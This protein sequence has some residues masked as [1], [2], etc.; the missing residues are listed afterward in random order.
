LPERHDSPD[1][2]SRWTF[3][4]TH[5]LGGGHL[6]FAVQGPLEL[7]AAAGTLEEAASDVVAQVA[8]MI[9]GAAAVQLP[10]PIQLFEVATC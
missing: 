8:R 1:P 6:V 5:A 7:R 10:E 4:R 3:A 2:W 9:G